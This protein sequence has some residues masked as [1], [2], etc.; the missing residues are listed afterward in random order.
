M[1]VRPSPIAGQWYSGDP[2]ELAHDVDGYI[3]RA[4]LPKLKGKLH[5]IVVPH[6]GHRYSGSVAGY[7]FAAIK[8]EKPDIVV[9]VS[10]MHHPYRENFLVTSHDAYATPLGLIPVDKD[11]IAEINQHLSEQG[12]SSLKAVSFDPEHSLEIEL[13]FLQ[14]IFTHAYRFLPI[15]VKSQS[16]VE[17]KSLGIALSKILRDK[18]YILIASTD[19]SHFYSQRIAEQLDHNMLQ[20]ITAL[21]PDQMYDLELRDGGFACGLG[22]VSAVIDCCCQLGANNAVL[23]NQSTSGAITGDYSSVV[24]YGAVAILADS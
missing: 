20:A 24:G 14:R 21:S 19:L 8:N 3:N 4:K 2:V 16:R 6:A 13:P 17:I 1:D 10:P 12:I 22:A 18:S 7:G 9:V 23:L 5:A 11:L 15:M